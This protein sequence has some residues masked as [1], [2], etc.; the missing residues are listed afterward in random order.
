MKTE[1][2]KADTNSVVHFNPLTSKCCWR[3]THSFRVTYGLW[4]D[5]GGMYI[6]PDGKCKC[7]ELDD[8]LSLEKKVH[9]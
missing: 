3:C 9:K 2:E 7:W 1:W 6:T 8:Y 4:C 5:Y